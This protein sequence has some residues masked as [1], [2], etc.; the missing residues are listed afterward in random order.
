MQE[1]DGGCSAIHEVPGDEGKAMLAA[2]F[3]PL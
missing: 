3:V 1:N 2:R